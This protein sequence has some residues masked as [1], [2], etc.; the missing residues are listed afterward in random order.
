MMPQVH[1]ITDATSEGEG[2]SLLAQTYYAWRNGCPGWR[3]PHLDRRPSTLEDP[4]SAPLWEALPFV[5]AEQTEQLYGGM[6]ACCVDDE[7]E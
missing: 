4:C 5:A 3:T 7:D 1:D 6:Y 2:A